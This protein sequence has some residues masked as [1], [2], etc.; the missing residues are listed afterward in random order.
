[1][2]S[3]ILF[4]SIEKDSD[5]IRDYLA[6]AVKG[7]FIVSRV[8]YNNF[9]KYKKIEIKQFLRLKIFFE[10]MLAIEDLFINCFAIQQNHPGSRYGTYRMAYFNFKNSE[11]RNFMNQRFDEQKCK[12][13]LSFTNLA[14]LSTKLNMDY[15]K[16]SRYFNSTAYILNS[17][18]LEYLNNKKA[19]YKLK[20]GFLVRN[21]SPN[22]QFYKKNEVF[23]EGRTQIKGLTSEYTPLSMKIKDIKNEVKN[24][25]IISNT[26][27][28]MLRV[29]LI[30]FGI[31]V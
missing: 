4:T 18:R 20:H 26:I 24:I 14:D 5:K 23:I 29:F 17:M 1:M 25:K 27:T 22:N 19:F 15:N 9:I 6:F 2:K 12:K 3:K 28:D 16:L 30:Q 13:L 10:Y 31:K 8:I 21:T 7:H 11:L